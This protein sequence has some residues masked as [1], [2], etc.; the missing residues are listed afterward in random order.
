MTSSMK[1]EPGRPLVRLGL[2]SVGD[3][4]DGVDTSAWASTVEGRREE[5][6]VDWG[7]NAWGGKYPPYENDDV[8]GRL[9]ARKIG[10][11]CYEPEI[12]MEGGAIDTD[13]LEVS[14]EDM[15][16]VLRVDAEELRAQLP[17]V[18]EHLATFG[19][20]LPPALRDE[21][22]ALERRLDG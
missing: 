13:G 16:A 22:A 7:Y 20:D 5:A 2:A 6:I 11:V 4:T 12:I 18:K 9:I 19:D 10:Y 14:S 1:S 21:L 3:A 17:Q 15:A 8:I